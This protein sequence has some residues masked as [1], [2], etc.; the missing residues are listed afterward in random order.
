M[1]SRI[2]TA[3]ARRPAARRP[4]PATRTGAGLLLALAAAASASSSAE[5]PASPV[6]VVA[7][8]RTAPVQELTLPADVLSPRRV[9]L[10]VEV[11]GLVEALLVDEGSQVDTGAPLLRLRALPKELE[12]RTR[13]AALARTQAAT[14]LAAAKEQRI[15]RLRADNMASEDNYDMVNAELAQARAEVQAAQAQLDLARDQLERHVVR[16]PFDGVISDKH[17]EAGAWLSPG[18]AVF[19]LVEVDPVRIEAPLPQAWL[20]HVRAGTPA[21]L[22]LGREGAEPVPVEVTR[23][24][25]VGSRATRTFPLQ[26]DLPN[27]TLGAA[28]GMAA[29]LMIEIGSGEAAVLSVPADALVRRPDGSTLLWRVGEA[30]GKPVAEPV[31]VQVG[32]NLGGRLEVSGPLAAG[33]RVVLEGNERLRPGQAVRLLEGS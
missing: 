3:P 17:V 18:D 31:P 1:N 16:A 29:D 22:R 26:I 20:G 2:P 33:D 4:R 12:V 11:P 6:R 14:K 23:V 8:E 19:T 7:V 10:S 24:I 5:E 25:G 30:D 15:G 13:R 28:P 9:E 27:D 32:R 21:R